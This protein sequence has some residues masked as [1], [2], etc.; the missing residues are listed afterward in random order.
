L[1]EGA[2]PLRGV[3]AVIAENMNDSRSM[4]TATSIRDVPAKLLEVNRRIVNNQLGRTRGGKVSF[5]HLIGWAIVRAL[6]AMPVM[7]S[8]YHEV[9]GKPH[10]RRPEHPNLGLAVDVE[11]KDGSHTL[12]VPNIKA[13]DTL[14]FAGFFRAYEDVVRRIKANKLD[15]ELF[16][17]TTVT[18]TNPGTVGT[19]G[20]VPRLMPGQSAIIGVGAIDYPAEYQGADPRT[21]AQIGVG[22]VITL[23]STYDHRVIQ[24]AESGLFLQTVHRLLLGERDFYDEIFDSLRIPYEPVRWRRDDHIASAPPGSAA[25]A[26]KQVAV[27]RLINAYRVRGHLI[28]NINPLSHT[29]QRV[30]V[31]LD[32]ATYGLTIWDLDR[33]FATGGLAGRERMTLGDILGVLRDAYCRTVGVEYMH[34]QQREEKR[35]IQERVEGVTTTLRVDEHKHI[36]DRLNNAEAFERFLHTKYIGHKRF[37]LEGAESAIP[38]LDA[39]LNAAADDGIGEAVIGM[40]HRGRLNVLANIL[41]KSYEK[42]F[43]EFEGDVDPDSVQGSGDVKYHLGARGRHTSPAGNAI[44]LT[45]SSNPSHLEAVNPV[46]EGVVRAKLDQAEDRTFDAHAPVLPVLVHG[47]AAFA[48]QGVVAETLALSQL[49]GYR[50]GGTVHLIINNQVGFTTGPQQARS[51]TYATDVAKMVQAPIFHVNGDDPEA[52]VRV[53]RLALAY[54]QCFGKDVVVDMLCYRRWGHN[55][56]D[57]PSYTQPIMYAAIE[58]RRSVRKLYTEE[59]VNRGAL[60]V[61]EAEQAL[62][63]FRAC[64]ETALKETRESMPPSAATAARPPKPVGV[65]PRVETGVEREVLDEIAAAVATAPD[66][67]TIHP[68]LAKQ[69][70]R[71]RGQLAGAA[72]DWAMGEAL[73]FGSLL[74]EGIPVRLA[75][76]DSRRG[77]FSQR[78]ATLVDYHDGSEWTPLDH[79]GDGAARFM[80]YDSPLSEFASLGFEYGYSV[81]RKDALVLWEAQF[82]D[83]VNGAQVIL[84]QFLVAAE[85][86]WG[87]TSGLVLLLP[88]GYEGQGP[89]HSSARKERFLT[90]AAEDNIQVAEPTTAAQYFH[91]LRRQ[92]HRDV[93]KPL[94]VITPK[95]LLRAKPASSPAAAFTAGCFREVLGEDGGPDPA[96]VRRVLLCSGRVAF[97]LIAARDEAAAPVAVVRVEQLYPWPEQQIREALERYPDGTQVTWVQDEPENMGA[98]PFAH[99][100]LHRLLRDSHRLAHVSRAESAS[101]ATGS[102]TVHEQEQRELIAAAFAGLADPEPEQ[103]ATSDQHAG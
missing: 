58:R 60:T 28:A 19:V 20:S 86:K 75:G 88:H 72:V 79:L 98:W 81:A 9:D 41:G 47:D 89:E 59:L 36:L 46:V 80:V 64:L 99:G 56:G 52:C 84:D 18:L 94:V 7:T 65:L 5:T 62:D 100:R 43:R 48:G 73:A 82:G 71:R 15:P 31:E 27:G 3:A 54:R 38:M 12:L 13:V 10:V 6:G 49:R 61:E 26:D 45:L 96:T 77:T 66:G 8:S 25:H 32:P 1:P 85:D 21:L 95:G 67:F 68:K 93:R 55:E 76:Q 22:K 103:I 42:I 39:V 4:P 44:A 90:S 50:T 16:A 33:E 102:A 97:D 70:D 30:H 40:A 2:A 24:G 23:T 83:F 78:H 57:D 74:R 92:M 35:W 37:S 53:M 101:P 63:E 34:I 11:R 51:S 91:L 17:D 14:D 29:F 87:Q 69:L